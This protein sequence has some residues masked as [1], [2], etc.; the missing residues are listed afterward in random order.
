MKPSTRRTI[1]IVSVIVL[2]ALAII[3]ALSLS[4]PKEIAFSGA[5]TTL[6]NL[7]KEG[8]ID[9]IYVDGGYRVNI[10]L[11]GEKSY[12]Y[13]CYISSRSDIQDNLTLWDTQIQNGGGQ[14]PTVTLVYNDPSSTSMLTSFLVPLL[15]IA[16]LAIVFVIIMRKSNG[17]NNKALNFGKTKATQV[18]DS[19]VRFTDVAGAEEEK[20]EL[21]EIVD[22][23]KDPKKFTEIGARIPKGVLLVGPPGTGKTLFAKAVAGEANVP[24]FSISGSDF[25]EMFVGVGASRVRDLFDQAKKSMPC[26]VFIDEI[27]AVGRQ[28]GAGLGGGNDERE[29]TLNQLLVQMDGF[30]SNDSIIVMAATNRADILDP[31]LMRPGRFDRQIYVN[32]PDVKGREEIFKVHSR[33]KPLASN[34]N[35]KN[36]ARLT[37]GFT[38][39]DIENLL[40]EAAILAARDNR[41]LISMED[42][43]E[44]INKVIAGPAKKSRVVTER[45][46]RI[47]AYH[48]SGHA[49]VAK[50][51]KNCDNV[52]EVSII[53]RGMA[54]GYTITLPE[55]DDNHYTKNKLL[56][57]IAMMLGGRAAEEI[58]IKDVSAG[59][60]NDIQR[61]SKIARK[62]VTEWGMSDEIGNLYL[63]ASEEVFIGRDYQ[64]QLS[65][66]DE[67]AAKIDKEVKSIIDKQYQAALNI[68]KENRAI[69]DKMV[70]A[71]YEKET[72][73][74]AE[75]DA[76]FETGEVPATD[77][78]ATNT[79]A[80]D[81]ATDAKAEDKK[82]SALPAADNAAEVKAANVPAKAKPAKAEKSASSDDN[83]SEDDK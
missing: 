41:K 43:S 33:N 28:R 7:Y 62:M 80:T 2:I 78:A 4:G 42:I 60:S 16:L 21:Q 57:Q 5:G 13:F 31:A 59:A 23:L 37:S 79:A 44:A 53:P 22:F 25:V 49:I 45:D 68:L 1:I 56:D 47:T 70:K 76:L 19:K 52:H 34:I 48:E 83:K 24:F 29:Q 63:G 20:Q 3:L 82:D 6:E 46:K 64:T 35:F 26:I 18:R 58:V 11:V 61:A 77:T 12:S 51:S 74:E 14:V 17:A 36:L 9:T 72:I 54:A 50:L 71:L 69:M 27:D 15:M 10:K 73:C 67:M 32:V 38:G 8:K 75:I 66:S 40:N 65:Y 55:N 30:E 81:T 39:A